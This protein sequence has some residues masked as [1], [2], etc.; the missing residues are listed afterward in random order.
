MGNTQGMG[1]WVRENLQIR[2]HDAVFSGNWYR[3][4]WWVNRVV[5]CAEVSDLD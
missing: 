5:G 2:F 3:P 4:Y 1:E